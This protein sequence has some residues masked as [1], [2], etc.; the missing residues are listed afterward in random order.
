MTGGLPLNEAVRKAVESGTCCAAVQVDITTPA[1]LE[2]QDRLASWGFVLSA[3]LPPKETWFEKDGVRHDVD[4]T[5]TGIWVKPRPDLPIEPPF[6]RDSPGATSAEQQ[7]LDYLRSVLTPE[8][9]RP[10]TES[11]DI[12]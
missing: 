4:T 9:A 12:A 11:R 7:I 10:S 5:A 3:V 6:Y 8:A 1:A 2:V